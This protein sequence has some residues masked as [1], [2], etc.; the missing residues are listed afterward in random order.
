MARERFPP[1][2][3]YRW[4]ASVPYLEA[5]RRQEEF[6]ARRHECLILCEHPATITLGTGAGPE[7]LPGTGEFYRRQGIEICRSPR[8]GKATYH[9]P[10]QLVGYPIVNL[11]G[12]GIT[13]HGH[14]RFLEELMIAACARFGVS[15]H[16]V[17]GKSGAWVGEKKIGFVGIRVR[18]GFAFHGFS[19]NITPQGDSFR[20]IIPCGMPGLEI[21]SLHE[22][23][24]GHAVTVW[25]AAEAVEEAF[26]EPLE[27]ETGIRVAPR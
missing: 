6:V 23:C 26:F 8:G 9:G 11:R 5:A 12:R 16:R 1:L 13:I 25:E 18:Q 24:N 4:G 15:A 27:L 20:W 7:D 10:G 21:T 14:L 19:L 3:V 22:E 2:P 17:E